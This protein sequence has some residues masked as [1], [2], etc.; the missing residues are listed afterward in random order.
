MISLESETIFLGFLS[1][2]VGVI[3]KKIL[4][5]LPINDEIKSK[6][7]LEEISFYL[8]GVIVHVLCGYFGIHEWFCINRFKL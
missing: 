8:I 4:S 6:Y 2:V 3:L 5:E 7:H 1:L